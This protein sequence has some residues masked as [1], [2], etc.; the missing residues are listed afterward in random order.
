MIRFDPSDGMQWAESFAS[1]VY[2]PRKALAR[3]KFVHMGFKHRPSRTKPTDQAHH[4]GLELSYSP[5]KSSEV[6]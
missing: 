4:F 3:T 1:V 6:K 5:L 2:D